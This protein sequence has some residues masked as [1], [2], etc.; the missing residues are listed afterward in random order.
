LKVVAKRRCA[1]LDKATL[2][3]K[4]FKILDPNRFM[5]TLKNIIMINMLSGWRIGRILM[6]KKTR[7]LKQGLSF[8]FDGLA[9]ID[10]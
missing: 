5:W 9:N 2:L 8:V 6:R 1:I 3:K 4:G 7:L 10:A